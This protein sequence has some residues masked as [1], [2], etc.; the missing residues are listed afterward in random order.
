MIPVRSQWGR[1]NLPR[2]IIIKCYI[3]WH[4][5]T[6]LHDVTLHYFTLHTL[7][8]NTCYN[9]FHWFPCRFITLCTSYHITLHQMTSHYTALRSITLHTHVDACRYLT[10]WVRVPMWNPCGALHLNHQVCMYVYTWY[11]IIYIYILY[12]YSDPKKIDR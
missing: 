2:Y 4:H 9:A 5:I 7:N 6:L 8:C 11:I 12:I 10:T 1:Y 3:R